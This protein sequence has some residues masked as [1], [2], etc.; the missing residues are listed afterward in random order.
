MKVKVIDSRGREDFEDRVNEFIK[1]KKVFDI[2]QT[3]FTLPRSFD[4]TGSPRI[5]DIYTR[6]VI[7]YE[8]AKKE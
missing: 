5:I 3:T 6:A 8:D 1:D 4:G 7:M 2:K